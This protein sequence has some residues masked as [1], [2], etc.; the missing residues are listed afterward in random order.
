MNELI[1]N[2]WSVTCALAP[3][4]LLG[5]VVAGALHGLFAPGFIERHL[6]GRFGVVKAVLLGVPLPLCSCGVI[7]AGLGLKES[8]ASDGAA[9]GF[10]TA[11]PQTGVDSVL[12]SA[13]MLGV[14][15]ALF[16]VIAALVTGLIS[17]WWVDLKA[18][19]TQRI[20]VP[21]QPKP[22][23][24]ARQMV[25]H[26]LEML[27]M[28][29]GW[30]VIG[31]VVSAA[32]ST[33]LPNEG[34]TG[35]GLDSPWVAMVAAL[36]LSL[37][38]YVCATASV[39]IAAAL[40]QAGLPLGA[41]LVF[42]M[43]G[44][45]TNVATLGAVGRTFGRRTLFIYV[46]TIVVG[47]VAF[48]LVFDAN[49]AQ[50]FVSDI[51]VHAH[52]QTSHWWIDASAVVLLVMLSWF[53]YESLQ[54]TI[55]QRLGSRRQSALTVEVRVQGMTCGGC[56]SRLERALNKSEGVDSASVVLDEAKAIVSGRLSVEQVSAIIESAGFEALSQP[57]SA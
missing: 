51:T 29:W 40:V 17:G 55:S 42:L 18:S 54:A 3:W 50:S 57:P 41:A 52:E 2:C 1:V 24:T 19:S 45:A 36:S 10:L 13:G 16:K 21:D 30:L 44:P 43:A 31:V 46:T 39:P 48:G 14:P 37:P 9:V 49:F 23:P 27:R 8:G 25:E 56:S 6:R 7:P 20:S 4:V 47:S 11:T 35:Y 12:V 5:A 32:L 34:L 38:L 22:R 15:F 28:V 33:W 53:A 26:A